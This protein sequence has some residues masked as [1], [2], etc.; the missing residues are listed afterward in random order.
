MK[1]VR[2]F[3]AVLLLV[4]LTGCGGP[5]ID[6]SSQVALE[7]SLERVAQSLS[8]EKRAEFGEA[9]GIVTMNALGLDQISFLQQSSLDRD[10]LEEKMRQAIHGKTAS[11]I[12]SAAKKIKKA[13]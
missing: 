7:I 5:T 8:V 9:F 2:S 6:A 12:I 10:Q 3:F 4:I 1:T 11:Q 13:Q